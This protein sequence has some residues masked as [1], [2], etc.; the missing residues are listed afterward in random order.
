MID[1]T[2]GDWKY[3]DRALKYKEVLVIETEDIISND[4]CEVNTLS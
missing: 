2:K 4:N 1:G 3:E